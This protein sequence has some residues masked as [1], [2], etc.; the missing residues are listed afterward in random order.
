M[1]KKNLVHNFFTRNAITIKR[2]P[3]VVSE[4]MNDSFFKVL[5]PSQVACITFTS[6]Q[7]QIPEK[8]SRFMQTH[9]KKTLWIEPFSFINLQFFL[10]RPP[11]DVFMLKEIHSHKLSL[12]CKLIT[13][14]CEPLWTLIFF[15]HGG[16]NRDDGTCEGFNVYRKLRFHEVL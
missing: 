4:Q 13:P 8:L 11:V 3:I 16:G 10:P 9:S 2:G 1:G 15:C 6:C 7:H 12:W 5:S 14:R